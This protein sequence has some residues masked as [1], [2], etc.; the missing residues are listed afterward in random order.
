MTTKN[1]SIMSVLNHV[2]LFMAVSSVICLVIIVVRG[3]RHG[4]SWKYMSCDVFD[5]ALFGVSSLVGWWL[6]STNALH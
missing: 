2:L 4:I 5:T 3:K 1:I 6:M